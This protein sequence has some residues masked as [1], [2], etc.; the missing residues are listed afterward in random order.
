MTTGPSAKFIF[1]VRNDNSVQAGSIAFGSI[2]VIIHTLRLL[3]FS[4]Y[5]FFFLQFEFKRE[6]GQ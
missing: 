5:L 1:S 3:R 6:N 4:A 2:Q